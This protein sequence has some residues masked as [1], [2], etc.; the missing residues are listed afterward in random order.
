MQAQ[1]RQM[2]LGKE[3]DEEAS[4][5]PQSMDHQVEQAQQ[6]GAFVSPFRSQPPMP[7]PFRAQQACSDLLFAS[8]DQ[9]CHHLFTR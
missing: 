5:A 9:A 8:L 6:Q 7:T 3:A 1:A 2:S 4:E